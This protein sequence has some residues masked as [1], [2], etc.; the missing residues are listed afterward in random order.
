MIE[1]RAVLKASALGLIGVTM[2]GTLAGLTPRQAYAAGA[3]FKV[4]YPTEVVSL[5]AL[6]EILVPGARAAGISNYV[7]EQLSRAPEDSLLLL[8]YLNV[9][10]PALSFYRTEIAS[11]NAAA[12]R[13]N[14]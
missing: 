1:R 4:L 9:P 3:R 2:G 7:D 14:G 6:A 11:L 13:E 12:A 5:E 8:R 10:V